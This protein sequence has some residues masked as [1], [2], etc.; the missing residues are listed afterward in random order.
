[1][2]SII[3]LFAISGTRGQKGKSICAAIKGKINIIN[4]V[5]VQEPPASRAI[6]DTL[7]WRHGTIFFPENHFLLNLLFEQK[8][9]LKPQKLDLK[10]NRKCNLGK[11]LLF[12]GAVKKRTCR[13][14]DI[15]SNMG[16]GVWKKP[17]LINICK[18]DKNSVEEG[19]RNFPNSQ[20]TN[21]TFISF[22]SAF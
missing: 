16:G 9:D 12:R 5:L 14:C 4:R 21:K 1:M 19:S 2:Y 3:W 6:L 18:W 7:Q 20:L 15:Y 8:I 11:N 13:I 10:F 17:I 22:F